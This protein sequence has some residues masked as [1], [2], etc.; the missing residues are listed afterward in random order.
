[1]SSALTR[2]DVAGSPANAPCAQSL[3]SWVTSVEPRRSRLPRLRLSARIAACITYARRAVIAWACS[4]PLDFNADSHSALRRGDLDSNGDALYRASCPWRCERHVGPD[5]RTPRLSTRRIAQ[6]DASCFSC[7]ETQGSNRIGDLRSPLSGP[8][9]S[10]NALWQ[11]FFDAYGADYLNVAITDGMSQIAVVV[12][13]RRSGHGLML[14]FILRSVT[15]D[16]DRLDTPRGDVGDVGGIVI[17]LGVARLCLH[18]DL[19]PAYR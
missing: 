13:R 5:R 11:L 18:G 17:Y 10:S 3:A 12:C 19:L 8:S 4:A 1:M 9:G 16:P 2:L 6:S 15:A 14:P 7:D